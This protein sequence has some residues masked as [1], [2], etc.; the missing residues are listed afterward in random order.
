MV[1]YIYIFAGSEQSTLIL[2]TDSEHCICAASLALGAMQVLPKLEAQAV[3]KLKKKKKLLE[4]LLFYCSTPTGCRC[5]PCPRSGDRSA[6]CVYGAILCAAQSLCQSSGRERQQKNRS[7]TVSEGWFWER[8]RSERC[9]KTR[10]RAYLLPLVRFGDAR[11][12]DDF[13]CINF[14]GGEVGHLVAFSKPSLERGTNC[15]NCCV[16]GFG[17]N[18]KQ[19]ERFFFF[20]AL[21]CPKLFPGSSTSPWRCR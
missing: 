21:P 5:S 20:F 8:R 1:F 11:V 9:A 15:V 19:K 4:D 12:W 18:S 3:T 10:L 6:Q 17:G 14:A 13:G 16:F 7:Q 2:V